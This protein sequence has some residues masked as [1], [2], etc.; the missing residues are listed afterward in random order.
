[1]VKR[2]TFAKR[3][4]RNLK[5]NLRE[6]AITQAIATGPVTAGLEYKVT[7]EGFEMH[8]SNAST[9]LI[10][11]QAIQEELGIQTH[12]MLGNTQVATGNKEKPHAADSG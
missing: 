8:S 6:N 7:G 1:M 4:R 2:K 5:H 9:A 11:A 10:A 3:T 12:V